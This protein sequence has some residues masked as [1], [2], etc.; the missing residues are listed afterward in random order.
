M[1]RDYLKKQLKLVFVNLLKNTEKLGINPI[2]L[3]RKN[4]HTTAFLFEKS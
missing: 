3:V 1:R 4:K 2:I